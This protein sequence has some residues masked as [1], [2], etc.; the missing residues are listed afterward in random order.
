MGIFRFFV[1]LFLLAH[2]NSSTHALDDGEFT[3]EITEDGVEITGCLDICPKNMIIPNE[4]DSHV[5]KK[6]SADSFY[7]SDID[8]IVIAT[9]ITSIG[10]NTFASNNLSEVILPPGLQSMGDGTVI[11]KGD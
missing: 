2:G 1:C 11:F 6:I 10:S 7:Q 8:T 3:Y 5:V 9:T 4:I